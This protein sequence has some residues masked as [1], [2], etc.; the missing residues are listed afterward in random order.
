M[1]TRIVDFLTGFTTSTAP[2]TANPSDDSDAVNKGYADNT[3]TPRAEVRGK[4]TDI[5]A[6]K[7]I[8]SADRFDEQI[9]Y[10]SSKMSIYEFDSASSTTPDDDLVVQPNTGTGRWNK[11]IDGQGSISAA[12]GAAGIDT[13]KQKL[14][15][16]YYDLITASLDNSVGNGF[17]NSKA[18]V[19]GRLLEDYASGTS[20]SICWNPTYASDSDKNFDATTGWAAQGA[21]ASLTTSGTHKV[22]TASL[23]FDKNNTDTN[24]RIRYD[25]GAATRSIVENTDMFFW[26]NLPSI[27]NLSNIEVRIDVDSTNYETYTATTSH[28]GAALTTGW[29]LMKF[30]LN[31]PGTSSGTGWDRTKLFRYIHVGLNTSSAAQT[32]TAVLVDGLA[33]SQRNIS[34]LIQVGTKYTIYDTADV[35]YF[36]VSSAS[37]RVAGT[38]TIAAGMSAAFDSGTDSSV[39][40]STLVI[41]GNNQAIMENGLSGGIADTQEVRLQRILPESLSGQNFKAFA[42]LNTNCIF[43]VAG[44]TDSD[45]ITVTDPV[46]QSGNLVSGKIIHVFK[47]NYNADGVADFENRGIDLTIS[48]SSHLSGVTTINTGTN[49]GI[50]AGDYVVLKHPTTK[51][52]L[53]AV[54]ANESFQSLTEDSVKL[55]NNG[56]KYFN[57]QGAFAHYLVGGQTDNIGIANQFGSAPSLSKTGAPNLQS[58]FLNGQ[59]AGT[60]F[61]DSNYLSLSAADSLII[62]G[63]AADVT[64]MQISFWMYPAAFTGTARIV[65]MRKTAVGSGNGWYIFMD[66]GANTINFVD[67]T[68]TFITT[69]FTPNAWNHFTYV[70]RSG[71]TS[72]AYINAVKTA[73]FTPTIT[74]NS[75]VFTIGRI[76]TGIGTGSTLGNSPVADLYITRNGSE[77][78]Q[79]EVEAIYNR[80]FHR[81]YGFGS[82]MEY[83]YSINS[84]TGQK[85]S[86]ESTLSRTTDNAVIFFDS[87]G[88]MKN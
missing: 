41:A 60:S 32:Y 79:G 88:G 28:T 66:S 56:V 1:A 22:G 4:V 78:T 74:T 37:A 39:Y 68:T 31:V 13:L 63:A 33:F 21:A 29:Q 16:E 5:T 85:L 69:A 50:V 52:S 43:E 12:G 51:L 55:F 6:L 14:D 57:Q 72:Y 44:V 58:A 38:I 64:L 9:I 81:K 27:T 10:V 42:R 24:A 2:A 82:M 87:V 73:T 36:I 77:V 34:R 46:D 80:G 35:D 11:T 30:D 18:T 26:I 49:T 75:T 86:L 15:N 48:S 8:A 67:N 20:L 70:I 54:S 40:R 59:Y 19:L 7:A 25:V 17:S 76:S 61:D 71:G 3:Y 45:T 47:P 53:V 83:N 65:M 23:S 84:L 62:S